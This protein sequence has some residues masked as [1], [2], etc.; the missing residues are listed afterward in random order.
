MQP[1]REAS[2]L[3]LA[4]PQDSARG[5]RGA[6]RKRSSASGGRADA[7]GRGHGRPGIGWVGVCQVRRSR[8][9]GRGATRSIDSGGFGLRACGGG[10]APL[11]PLI[12]FL[13]EARKTAGAT[14]HS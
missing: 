3:N 12:A 8:V 14:A 9:G 2:H 13:S 10:G 7:L 1:A 11:H 6:G 5:I 4:D